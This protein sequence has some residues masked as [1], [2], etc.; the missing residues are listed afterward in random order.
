M[1]SAL[2]F[3]GGAQSVMAGRVPSAFSIQSGSRWRSR[4]DKVKQTH[5]L[6]PQKLTF[7]TKRKTTQIPTAME[8]VMA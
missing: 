8:R 5:V 3:L 7:S 1:A 4:A 6:P 2:L